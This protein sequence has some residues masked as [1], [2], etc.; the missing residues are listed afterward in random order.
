MTFDGDSDLAAAS[1]ATEHVCF[2]AVSVER[3]EAR[4]KVQCRERASAT[5]AFYR[6]CPQRSVCV[7]DLCIKV[8]FTGSVSSVEATLC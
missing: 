4:T 2:H 3:K 5:E 1:K 8:C 6:Q 7:L